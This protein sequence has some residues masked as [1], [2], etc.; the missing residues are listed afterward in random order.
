MRIPICLL[1]LL[2]ITRADTT[3][4][5][6]DPLVRFEVHYSS[7]T[8]DIGNYDVQR[9]LL[10]LMQASDDDGIEHRHTTQNKYK[11]CDIRDRVQH[12]D[13]TFEATGAWG[14]VGP[15]TKAQMQYQLF[16]IAGHMLDRLSKP[17]RWQLYT[18]C[19]S[20]T[21]D[22]TGDHDLPCGFAASRVCEEIC[23]PVSIVEC[24]EF[25]WAHRIPAAISI[26]AYD[27]A[28]GALRAD[29][30]H[31]KFSSVS[32][33][34]S[35]RCGLIVGAVL[36]ALDWV[37]LDFVRMWNRF[38]AAEKTLLAPELDKLLTTQEKLLRD[39]KEARR[40]P[41]FNGFNFAL[42]FYDS[43]AM[44]CRAEPEGGW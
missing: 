18:D 12:L 43:I 34:H 21:D 22:P 8:V 1:A 11:Q 2:S 44:I 3:T 23:S 26:Y 15:I 37:N 5:G 25:A 7:S 42:L 19:I 27:V 33:R 4:I 16:N 10:E 28:T 39:A 9:A 13:V 30:L 40:N 36:V 31:L 20:K 6:S 17:F 29:A 41:A 38:D 35:L 14:D 24:G 32:Y